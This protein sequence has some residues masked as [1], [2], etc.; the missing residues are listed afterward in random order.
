MKILKRL[1]QR[2]PKAKIG[3]AER[4]LV[5]VDTEGNKWYVYRDPLQMHISRKLDLQESEAFLGMN[6][7]L[8]WLKKH[9]ELML[10]CLNKGD[11]INAIIHEQEL[12]I[13]LE[14]N[15]SREALLHFCA[16][17]YLIDGEPH[18]PSPNHYERK[19][20]LIKQYPELQAFFLDDVFTRYEN[21]TAGFKED[22]ENYC[23]KTAPIDRQ[24][25][26][27]SLMQSFSGA[28]S[29]TKPA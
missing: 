10:E 8:E 23:R 19:K 28:M 18:E 17:Y 21:F 4:I 14:L 5:H 24:T 29:S 13:R 11:Q 27:H 6:L 7:S 12:K 1:F 20:E 25:W 2:K 16:S 3:D 26:N 9:N 15:W 22:F